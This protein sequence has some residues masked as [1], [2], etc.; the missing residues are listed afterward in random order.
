MTPSA[1]PAVKTAVLPATI[2]LLLAFGAMPVW[3]APA[4]TGLNV[5]AL[6]T[7]QRRSFE[8]DWASVVGRAAPAA[9]APAGGA[10]VR[11][12]TRAT[13]ITVK[14]AARPALKLAPTS[15]PRS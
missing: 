15:S 14:A 9:L 3:A 8:T 12:K 11:A 1:K 4:P 2:F 10:A 13:R 7:A 5:E 6:K